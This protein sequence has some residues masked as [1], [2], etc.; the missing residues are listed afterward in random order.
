MSGSPWRQ[1]LPPGGAHDQD[2]TPSPDMISYGCASVMHW[3]VCAICLYTTRLVCYVLWAWA[4]T[5]WSTAAHHFDE[6]A[7]AVL[8][9]AGLAPA[10]EDELAAV[11]ASS[12]LLA[13]RPFTGQSLS[14]K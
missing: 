10:L 8:P 14:V 2:P 4:H 3:R 13:N 12:G 7:A 1:D 6:D 11:G 5:H 9:L